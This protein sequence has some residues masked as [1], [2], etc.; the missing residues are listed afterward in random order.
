MEA[1]WNFTFE[2]VEQMDELLH[3]AFVKDGRTV[4]PKIV[5]EEE[6]R[7]RQSSGHQTHT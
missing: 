1:R 3:V 4:P 2:G 6:P 7:L 5:E